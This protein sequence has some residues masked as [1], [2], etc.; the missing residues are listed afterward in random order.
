MSLSSRKVVGGG[1]D[2]GKGGDVIL[3]INPHL[4]DLSKFKGNKKFI[5]KDGERGKEKNKKGKDAPALIVNVPCGT[6]VVEKDQ[7]IVD[8]IN[9]GDEFLICHGGAGGKG[10]YK[11]D[12]NI[13]AQE[14]QAKEVVLDYRIPNDVA[15]LGFPNS[16]KTSLF[17]I[18]TGHNYKVAHYPFTTT[19]CRNNG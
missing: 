13:P 11:R 17:N 15:I 12:Y 8:L 9:E 1:G 2:G 14:G 10:N 6:R 5:A 16:G 7:L 4:Y 18:L 3:Q 19:S